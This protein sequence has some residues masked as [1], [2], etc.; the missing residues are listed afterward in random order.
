[1]RLVR[2]PLTAGLHACMPRQDLEGCIASALFLESNSMPVL[3]ARGPPCTLGVCGQLSFGTPSRSILDGLWQ[4]TVAPS[5]PR[6]SVVINPTGEQVL[7]ALENGVSQ[8]PK[9]EGRF[10]QV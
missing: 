9:L 6:S 3:C 8:Y 5:W 1:M 4:L 2:A 7:G 10:P